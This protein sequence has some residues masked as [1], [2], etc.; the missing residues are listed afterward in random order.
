MMARR[1]KSAHAVELVV[2]NH[3]PEPAAGSIRSAN[4]EPADLFNARHYPTRATCR[5]CGEAIA[6]DSFLRAF[7]HVEDETP[8]S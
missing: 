2:R 6:A 3:S 5:V 1:K 8:E 7:R 4:G